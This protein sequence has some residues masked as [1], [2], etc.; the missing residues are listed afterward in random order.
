MSLLDAEGKFSEDQAI[1]ASGNT[2]ST[3]V[4]DNLVAG[5][6]GGNLIPI[7]IKVTTA[8]A[9]A[10]TIANLTCH[11]YTGSTAGCVT[12]LQSSNT[13]TEAQLVA[14][15]KFSMASLPKTGV[16]QYLKF[17]FSVAG[18]KFSAGKISAYLGTPEETNV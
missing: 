3:N 18:A 5:K 7:Q 10:T 12:L 4:V 16:L 13:L 17:V 6:G 8:F 14:G 11:L 15:A 9:S 1:T 2:N